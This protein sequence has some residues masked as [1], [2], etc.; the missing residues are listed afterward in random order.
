MEEERLATIE[1]DN[2]ILLSKMSSIMRSTGMVDHIN[3]YEHKSLNK[4]KRQRELL[5]VAT[6]RYHASD[7][8]GN[9]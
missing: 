7:A 9:L 6:L 1:R 5:K 3:D 4:E 2:R 8:P